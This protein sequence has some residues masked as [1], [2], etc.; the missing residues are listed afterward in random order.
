MRG[1]HAVLAAAVSTVLF[2]GAVAV[3]IARADDAPDPIGI[4]PLPL[5]PI[6]LPPLPFLPQPEPPSPPSPPK[7]SH[8]CSTAG[9]PFV[10][11]TIS[12]EGIDDRIEFARELD[13]EP[14]GCPGC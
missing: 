12:L 9:R 1:R 8:G 14:L 4:G 5:P 13:A 2:A 11:R 10:P 6:P 7:P 3:P